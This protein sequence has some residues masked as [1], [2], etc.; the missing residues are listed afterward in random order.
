MKITNPFYRNWWGLIFSNLRVHC[1]GAV[2]QGQN[3]KTTAKQN[4]TRNEH[5]GMFSALIMGSKSSLEKNGLMG[6][7]LTMYNSMYVVHP[8]PHW[9][10]AKPQASIWF[11][12]TNHHGMGTCKIGIEPNQNQN[13]QKKRNIRY[14]RRSNDCSA[15]L[16]LWWSVPFCRP[17]L[18]PSLMSSSFSLGTECGF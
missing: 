12:T 18:P 2:C 6:L 4:R 10:T 15:S 3:N 1:Q 16:V 17:L 13:L 7:F 5:S 14:N 11:S 8:R 9:M